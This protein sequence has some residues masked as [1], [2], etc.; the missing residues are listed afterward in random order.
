MPEKS[1]KNLNNEELRQVLESNYD[2]ADLP[3][4]G[5]DQPASNT[6]LGDLP[7]MEYSDYQAMTET[8]VDQLDQP[9]EVTLL[10]G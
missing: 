1:A 6:W 3:G 7:G 2:F 8:Q 5:A 9:M 10:Y 4:V